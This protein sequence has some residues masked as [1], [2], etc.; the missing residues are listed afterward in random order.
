[1]GWGSEEKSCKI[2]DLIVKNYVV[3]YSALFGL[4][5]LS[6]CSWETCDH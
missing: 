6:E 2:F 4:V 3:A 1:M 5:C